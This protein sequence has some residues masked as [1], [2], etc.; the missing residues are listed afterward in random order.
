MSSFCPNTIDFA[1][2]CPP[3][4]RTHTQPCHFRRLIHS[5]ESQ[6]VKIIAG[7]LRL[8]SMNYNLL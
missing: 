5:I 8:S 3:P 6:D 2:I 7:I 4:Y 1:F